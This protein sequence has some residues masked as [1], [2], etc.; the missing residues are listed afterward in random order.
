MTNLKECCVCTGCCCSNV[1]PRLTTSART[2]Q[3]VKVLVLRWL[4]CLRTLEA[5]QNA[6]VLE[7]A[8]VLP[9]PD[10]TGALHWE[11]LEELAVG[12]SQLQRQ[13][14]EPTSNLLAFFDTVGVAAVHGY[15]FFQANWKMFLEASKD[16]P[17]NADDP[18]ELARTVIMMLDAAGA[19]CLQH[20]YAAHFRAFAVSA[21]HTPP[22]YVARSL[23]HIVRGIPTA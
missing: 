23:M 12:K 18:E 20:T 10:L 16:D 13:L 17:D 15:C 14:V 22:T 2:L 1:F 5:Q 11:A 9:T 6:E 8:A 4:Q 21:S 3:G 19:Q 7:S